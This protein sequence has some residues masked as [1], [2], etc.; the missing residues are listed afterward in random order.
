MTEAPLWAW[1]VFLAFVGVMLA[2]DLGVF[3]RQAHVVSFR[4]AAIWSVI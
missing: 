4:E 2:I 1:I 3:H